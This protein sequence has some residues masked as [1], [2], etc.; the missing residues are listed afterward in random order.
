MDLSKVDKISVR[1]PDVRSNALLIH[2]LR[3]LSKL[4]SSFVKRRYCVCILSHIMGMRVKYGILLSCYCLRIHLQRLQQ[5]AQ[6]VQQL[7]WKTSKSDHTDHS[8]A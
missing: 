1:S 3:Y 7:R 4:F 6:E 2:H 8:L 5:T